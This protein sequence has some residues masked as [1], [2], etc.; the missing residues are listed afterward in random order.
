VPTNCAL[1]VYTFGGWAYISGEGD[2]DDDSAD[3]DENTNSQGAV[4]MLLFL[5][6]CMTFMHAMLSSIFPELPSKTAVQLQ[7]Q[8]VVYRRVILG[9]PEEEDEL[10]DEFK[11]KS[12]FGKHVKDIRRTT[13]MRMSI[14]PMPGAGDGAAEEDIMKI[15]LNPDV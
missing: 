2:K 1:I 5:L 8:D 15:T 11:D 3:D 7:R 4:W 13:N 14:N 12:H 9:E 10:P 6:V